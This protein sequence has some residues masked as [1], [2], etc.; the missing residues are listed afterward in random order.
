MDE[1]LQEASVTKWQ[2]R[3]Q[4]ADIEGF[5]PRAKHY[6]GLELAILSQQIEGR[7]HPSCP[8]PCTLDL[9]GTFELIPRS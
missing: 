1:A 2:K 9:V 4:L 6:Q 7:L 5:P 3:D 8:P